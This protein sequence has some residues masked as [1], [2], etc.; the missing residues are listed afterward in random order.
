MSELNVT[1]NPWRAFP[2][3]DTTIRQLQA[4]IEAFPELVLDVARVTF[5]I[6]FELDF[7]H[8][9]PPPSDE[10]AAVLYPEDENLIVS[11]TGTFPRMKPEA[12]EKSFDAEAQDRNAE[13]V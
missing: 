4:A 3:Q 10:L 9:K 5:E 6:S 7:G 11:E 2:S 8:D 12:I 13:G 1:P